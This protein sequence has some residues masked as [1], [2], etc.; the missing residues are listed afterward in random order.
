MCSS[1]AVV[2]IPDREVNGVK[3]MLTS[4]DQD[5]RLVTTKDDGNK[6]GAMGCR[7]QCNSIL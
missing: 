6:H 7:V 4:S 5:S 2:D 3:I 1:N